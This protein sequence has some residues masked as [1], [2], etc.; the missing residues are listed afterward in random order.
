VGHAPLVDYIKIYNLIWKQA[1]IL[2]V[3]HVY[4][5]YSFFDTC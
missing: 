2:V 3:V 4:S 1:L 5:I